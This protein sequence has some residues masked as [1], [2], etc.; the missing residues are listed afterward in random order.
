MNCNPDSMKAAAKRLAA[1]LN[2]SA[3]EI[4]AMPYADVAWWLS[5]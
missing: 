2:F 1:E 3:E 4:M 5:D